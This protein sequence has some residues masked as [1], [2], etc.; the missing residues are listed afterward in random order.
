[1]NVDDEV[2]M[3]RILA[4]TDIQMYIATRTR[5]L[6]KGSFQTS[7]I[8]AVCEEGIAN[9]LREAKCHA[10]RRATAECG[11]EETFQGSPPRSASFTWL[12]MWVQNAALFNALTLA[13]VV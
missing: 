13:L 4:R 9:G 1:M 6:N 8:H 2:E 10:E 7:T 3:S 12:R 5:F 11:L